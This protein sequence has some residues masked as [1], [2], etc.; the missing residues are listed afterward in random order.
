MKSAYLPEDCH[1]EDLPGSPEEAAFEA[2]CD[3]CEA[4]KCSICYGRKACDELYLG[5]LL[6]ACVVNLGYWKEH[7]ED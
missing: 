2:A 1:V 3:K 6:E 7:K 4:E 5:L